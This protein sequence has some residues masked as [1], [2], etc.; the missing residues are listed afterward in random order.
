MGKFTFIQTEVPGIVIVEPTV[1]GDARGYF[2]ETYQKEEFVNAGIDVDFVQDNV[3]KSSKGVLRGLHYQTENTQ[4]K[5]VRVTKGSVFDVGVDVRPNSPHFGRWVGVELNEEN[6]RMLYVPEGFA[7]GFLVLSD[8]AEFQ[9]KCS[10][11]YHPKSEGGVRYDDADI[12]IDW[13]KLDCPHT[14]SDK[15]AVLPLL[16]EQSYTEFERWFAG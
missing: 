1:Y 7:H 11:Y 15:D 10:D 13:P 16:N 3:S 12:G 6:K 4:A 8:E 2:M 9:Y 5:L 14:L